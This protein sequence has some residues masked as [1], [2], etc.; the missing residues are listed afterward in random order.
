MTY[1]SQLGQDRILDEEIFRGLRGGVFVDVGAYDGTK[2]SNTRFFEEER[3]WTGVCIEPL[4]DVFEELQKNRRCACVRACIGDREGECRFLQVQCPQVDTAMLSGVVN[5]YDSRHLN[6][7]HGEVARFGGSA[8][9]ITVPLRTLQSVLVELGIARVDFISID[10]EGSE[11]CILKT[12]D[13]AAL[14]VQCL[15]VENN[16]DDPQIEAIL[17]DRG[18]R[19]FKTLHGYE[20]IYVS[21]NR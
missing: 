14:G 8:T 21:S 4:P 3:G 13:P 18:Y 7:V 9:E 15:L 6:R 16:Y 17:R 5:Q 2:Y 20:Q 19:L 1:Y 11:I 12:F 10:T